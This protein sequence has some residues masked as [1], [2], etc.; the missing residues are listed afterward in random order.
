MENVFHDREGDCPMDAMPKLAEGFE[1][2][3]SSQTS[4]NFGIASMGQTPVRGDAVSV[5]EHS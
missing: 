2:G 4:A 5:W 1:R 3:S